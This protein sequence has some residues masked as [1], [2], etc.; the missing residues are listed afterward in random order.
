M[1]SFLKAP[2]RQ[3]PGFSRLQ[4]S[5][6]RLHLRL[7]LPL[8]LERRHLEMVLR[9]PLLFGTPQNPNPKLFYHLEV[10]PFKS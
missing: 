8:K 7:T 5:L 10:H 2:V 6:A 4:V 9:R 3:S 1:E